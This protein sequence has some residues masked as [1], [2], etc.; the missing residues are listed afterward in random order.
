MVD[1]EPT[2]VSAATAE[3]PTVVV[4]DL[5][6][7]YAKRPTN[8]VDGV[9]FSVAHGEVFGLLGPNGAGKTTTVGVLTTRVR[10]TSGLAM[11]AGIDVMRDPV[12]AKRRLATVPQRSNLD[13]ALSARQI[14]L[15]HGAYFGIGAA[16]RTRR[17]N[18]LL[19][20]FGLLDRADD[21]VDFFSGGQSQRIMIA[22][23]LMHQPEV[24]FLDEPTT[25]LDPQ[26]RLFVWD[27]L[28]DL[29]SRGVTMI[30]TTHD[31]DE[32]AELCD[33]LAIMDHGKIL[34]MDTPEA[35]TETVPGQNSLEVGIALAGADRDPL[36][37]ALSAVPGVER[38]EPVSKSAGGGPAAPDGTPYHVRLYTSVDA[39][40]LVAPV[41]RLITDNGGEL[42]DLSIGKPS[43]EDVFIHLTG[44]A[45]R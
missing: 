23:A 12:A 4:Q 39:P 26:A 16:E 34:A 42:V 11:V 17:A 8:A 37:A 25:G 43:L 9:S 27:R 38:A 33:R 24:L 21:K 18:A 14:L 10:P 6:K 29:R 41:A 45:L 2:A 30:L 22:R 13:R 40:A 44:R 1:V 20:E 3:G 28:R 32:A 36:L 35:L 7:R 15:F 31:M 19:E 5:V